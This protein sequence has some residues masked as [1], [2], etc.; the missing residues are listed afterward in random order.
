MGILRRIKDNLLK[1][2][3]AEIVRLHELQLQSTA[4]LYKLWSDDGRQQSTKAL[5]ELFFGIVR[6][7]QPK[8]FIEAGAK[9][10]TASTRA[11]KLLPDARIVAFEANPYN[12]AHFSKDPKFT[13]ARVEYT[14]QALTNKDGSVTF[15]IRKTVNGEAVDPIS[16]QNSLLQ[17]KH[18]DTTYEEVTV[19]AK[20]LD[21]F[22]PHPVPN[23]IWM[24]VEGATGDVVSGAERVLGQTQVAIVEMSDHG[25]WKGEWLSTKVITHFYKRGLVPVARDFEYK[26]Q[27][28][29]V[30]VREEL[31]KSNHEVRRNI[32]YFFSELSK[33]S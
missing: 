9:E 10:A 15:N 17:Q 13:K 30:F 14:H 32:E 18:A 8:L 33:K 4:G 2:S 12:F 27:Y 1:D 24:D 19:P 23:A 28:N 5:V 3:T 25:K 16:G 26:S 29:V 6:I 7:T 11:G 21:S 20:R 22:F 31:L